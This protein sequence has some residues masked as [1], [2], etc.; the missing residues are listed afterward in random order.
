MIYMTMSP[1]NLAMQK[2]GTSES[3]TAKPKNYEKVPFLHTKAA[4]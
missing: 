1:V 2:V 3:K 4:A